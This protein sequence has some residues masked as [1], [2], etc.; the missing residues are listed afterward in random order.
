MS[1]RLVIRLPCCKDVVLLPCTAVPL[2]KS[3]LPYTP[4]Q[5]DT[6]VSAHPKA[7]ACCACPTKSNRHISTETRRVWKELGVTDGP[8][9][10]REL[11]LDDAE[12]PWIGRNRLP[13]L[14]G[15][16]EVLDMVDPCEGR[17]FDG[18]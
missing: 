6:R 9:D 1:V 18:D 4:V 13:P 3:L 15:G 2:G 11:L 7:H 17:P 8:E 10:G 5:R 14:L 12:C 16:R